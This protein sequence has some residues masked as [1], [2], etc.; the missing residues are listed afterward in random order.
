MYEK[1]FHSENPFWQ[2]MGRLFDIV[3]LNLLWLLCSIPVFTLGPSSA[4]L[5]AAMNALSRDKETYPHRDFF[6]AFRK[7]F[8]RNTAAGMLL[9]TLGAFLWLDVRI[10]R[11]S[12]H[13][14]FAFLMVFFFMLLLFWLF[15]ALYALPLLGFYDGGVKNTLILAFTLSL[16][17]FP[18][19]AALLLITAA[20][21]WFCHLFPPLILAAAGLC[22]YAKLSV[23]APVLK[24]WIPDADAEE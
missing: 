23:L 12:G 11:R 10:C 3:E 6:H 20:A 13:G 7:R 18:R 8:R 14:I 9:L 15:T 5:Y 21:L 19:T 1:I 22:V 2:G 17:H 4:A 24:P 16:R